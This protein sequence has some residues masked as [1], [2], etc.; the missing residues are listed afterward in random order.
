M[1]PNHFVIDI[2]V[3]DDT[4]PGT[5]AFDVFEQIDAGIVCP[6]DRITADSSNDFLELLLLPGPVPPVG[7]RQ[8]FLDEISEAVDFS[9]SSPDDRFQ[10]G[11]YFAGRNCVEPVFFVG[12]GIRL[13]PPVSCRPFIGR[14]NAHKFGVPGC[15]SLLRRSRAVV[16]LIGSYD[17]ESVTVL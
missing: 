7:H 2:I 3:E 6:A 9:G 4:L 8:Y 15:L 5:G 14:A 1:S 13:A 17:R 16:V 12:S 11:D 10:N